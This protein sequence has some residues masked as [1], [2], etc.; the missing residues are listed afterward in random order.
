MILIILDKQVPYE[1]QFQL[2]AS[3]L[4][5][6]REHIFMFPRIDSARQGLNIRDEDDL[7][8]TLIPVAPF[9]NMD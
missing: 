2:P 8:I 4:C 3:A 1:D 5:W 6:E 9:T 7:F